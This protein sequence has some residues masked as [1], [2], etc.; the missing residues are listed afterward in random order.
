MLLAV[1]CLCHSILVE[2][3][4]VV[5]D[6]DGQCA[7]NGQECQSCATSGME[8]TCRQSVREHKLIRLQETKSH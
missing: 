7:E 5:H 3:D 1:D 2:E 8:D 4:E 6:V